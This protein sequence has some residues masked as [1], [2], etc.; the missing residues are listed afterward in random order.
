MLERWDVRFC[1]FQ[2]SI[3][4]LSPTTKRMGPRNHQKFNKCVSRSHAEP[5]PPSWSWV[6]CHVHDEP[7]HWKA[8]QP[9]ILLS[10]LRQQQINPTHSLSLSLSL[11]LS[12][13]HSLTQQKCSA[14]EHDSPLIRLLERISKGIPTDFHALILFLGSHGLSHFHFSTKMMSVQN[15]KIVNKSKYHLS[16]ILVSK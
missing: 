4:P 3:A 6:C 2:R 14:H 7:S 12:P 8:V 11:S 10:P 9:A 1:T 5:P 16:K 15:N 13:T